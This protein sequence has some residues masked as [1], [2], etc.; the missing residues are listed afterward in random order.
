MGKLY[1]SCQVVMQ[2]IEVRG[3]DTY[4]ARGALAMET[5]FLVSTIGPGDA[6]DTSRLEKL[7]AAAKSLYGIDIP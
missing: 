6:D 3:L 5:G 2:E 1:E 4:K 7:R